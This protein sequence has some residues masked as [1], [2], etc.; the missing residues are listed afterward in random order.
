MSLYAVVYTYSDDSA[1]RDEHRPAHRTFLGGLADE[2]VVAA[3][4]PLRG[5]G[6]DRAL[7]LLERDSAEAARELL[8]EDPFAQQGL[9]DSVDVREWDVVIGSIA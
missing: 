6:P 9:I 2:G 5:D 1:G 7:I 4:G 8:R 3:S